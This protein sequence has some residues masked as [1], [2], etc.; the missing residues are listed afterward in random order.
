MERSCKKVKKDTYSIKG[1]Q[2]IMKKLNLTLVM[3][4]CSL[5]LSAQTKSILNSKLEKRKGSEIGAKPCKYD[6]IPL[7]CVLVTP[8][9][10]ALIRK[11]V[12]Q[13]KR[14]QKA[15]I[16]KNY[17][18]AN[19]DRWLNRSI[20]VP[21]TG[22]WI[23]DFFCVD[24]SMLE[25]PQ[26]RIFNPDLPSKCP[27]CGTT[28]L[29]DNI[30]AARR[31]FK[32]YCLFWAV[33]EL[34]LFFAIAGHIVFAKIY[35]KPISNYNFKYD[36]KEKPKPYLEKIRLL[37]TNSSNNKFSKK[38]TNSLDFINQLEDILGIK[39]SILR[40]CNNPPEEYTKSGIWFFEGHKRWINSPPML[41]LYSLFIRIGCNHK[42]GNSYKTTIE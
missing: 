36:P 27:T 3:I 25:L 14:G 18:K 11:E 13:D 7:P 22:G 9:R 30:R 35:D 6:A 21:E 42:K 10:L 4:V 26:D 2:M 24:G 16:Y 5:L 1:I 12:L 32:H 33:R 28:Y 17:V 15:I 20:T 31:A 41:S 19:A 29:N 37:T 38:I 8:D 23:H 39:K 40:E 34:V